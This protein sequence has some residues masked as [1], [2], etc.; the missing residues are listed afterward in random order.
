M[1]VRGH[2]LSAYYLVVHKFSA[3]YPSRA[4]DVTYVTYVTG[5]R[6]SIV[7]FKKFLISRFQLSP[8]KQV[9][10]ACIFSIKYIL[11]LLKTCHK[12][13]NCRDLSCNVQP[14]KGN[15]IFPH[16]HRVCLICNRKILQNFKL[17]KLILIKSKTT[18]AFTSLLCYSCWEIA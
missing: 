18:K 13:T 7:W 15:K 2:V 5:I 11:F 6:R 1:H 12:R 3:R 14:L 4:M 10:I 9:Q 16:S 8:A 17:F